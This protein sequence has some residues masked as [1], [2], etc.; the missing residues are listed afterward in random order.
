MR[1]AVWISVPLLLTLVA[2][3]CQRDE[4]TGPHSPQP[5]AQVTGASTSMDGSAAR[6]VFT[7][8]RDGKYQLYLMNADGSGVTRLTTN[9]AQDL[10]PRMSRDGRRILFTSDRDGNEEI[11]VMTGDGS[12]PT[13]LTNNPASDQDADWSPDERQIVFTT[14]RDGGNPE[15]YVMNADGSGQTR[16]TN[17]IAEDRHARWSP[18]G[19]QIVWMSDLGR[20][21]TTDQIYLMNADGSAPTRVTHELTANNDP[22]WS[23]DGQQIVFN[24]TRGISVIAPDGSGLTHLTTSTGRD[25]SWSPDGRRIVFWRHVSATNPEIFVMNAD[26]SGETRLTTNA[27]FDFLP[28][29]APRD[30]PPQLT[31][32]ADITAAAT[33]LS[34]AVVEYTTSATDPTDPNP[35]VACTPVSGTRFPIG[36]TSVQCTA[37]DGAWNTVTG[38]FRVIVQ[39]ADEQLAAVA[40][41]LQAIVTANPG[42]PLANKAE[43]A[44]AKVEAARQQLAQNPDYRTGPLGELKDAVGALAGAVEG[45]LLSAAQGNGLMD[46]ITNA[47]RLLAETAIAAAV[48]R[49]ANP[50]DIAQAEQALAAGDDQRA[51][52]QYQDAV[53]QY[54]TASKHAED[55]GRAPTQLAFGTEPP[56][57]VEATVAMATA[58]R[59][60]VQDAFGGTVPKATTVVTVALAPN[61]NGAVLGGTTTVSAVDGIA[62]FTDLSVDRPGSAY[63]LTATAAGLAGAT[64]SP[65]AV[66]VT[67]AF[68]NAGSRESCGLTAHGGG[69]CWGTNAW[70]SLGSGK[71]GFGATPQDPLS[72]PS[73]LPVSGGLVFTTISVGRGVDTHACGVTTSGGGYCW[74]VGF[75][76]QRGDGTVARAANTPRAVLGGFSFTTI[77]AGGIHTCGVTTSG[78]AYCWGS[79]LSGALGTGGF[80]FQFTSPTTP[81]AGG[82]SFTTVSAGGGHTCGVTT[83]GAAYCWGS[84]G[85]G[86]LGDGTNTTR[87]GPVPIAGG[88][89]F[90]TISAGSTYSCGVT[91]DGTAYC[92]GSNSHGELGDG[93]MAQ[94]ATPVPVA[95]NLRFATISAGSAH[96]CGV[97]TS[98]DAFCWGANPD[99][100]LGDGTTTQAP[101]PVPV[102]GGFA[103]S[104]V[105]AGDNHSCGVTTSREAYCWGANASGQLGNGTQ[106]PSLT[107]VPVATGTPSLT[108]MSTA[109]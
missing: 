2:Q 20:R 88:L 100:R 43:D 72:W 91:T 83:S 21:D 32:P 18:D 68:V 17:D 22:S 73:V 97:T 24:S 53:V 50:Q 23:P 14:F 27:A 10:F 47:G 69:Y 15:I 70:G 41:D 108:A 25:P 57:S 82:F 33:R 16:L 1:R 54:E 5:S 38:G 48:A 11:Y 105:R 66:H 106:T 93:T 49:G 99:G 98:G 29:W 76:G 64:S 74:G 75:D 56:A 13:R 86:Q 37:S 3:A 71:G 42:T 104:T 77:S 30:P 92:W 39:N 19:R 6:I 102:A 61:S 80:V 103:F 89:S 60:L 31:L 63:T 8:D 45:G 90:T 65:F 40:S 94:Q 107:P 55:H 52:G 4:A 46:R 109:P 26:G 87:L 9:T 84:N 78:A 12:A 44:R 58:V 35:A 34:G 95:G 59:V 67:F 96:T 85:S 79:G 51:A 36:T 101:T 28:S 62:T 81:V 7:S